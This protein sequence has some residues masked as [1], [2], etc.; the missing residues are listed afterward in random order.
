MTSKHTGKYQIFSLVGNEWYILFSST[1]AGQWYLA[2]WAGHQGLVLKKI[3]V[4]GYG[5]LFR[6]AFTL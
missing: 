1:C 4:G 3:W 6:S 5:P 2:A